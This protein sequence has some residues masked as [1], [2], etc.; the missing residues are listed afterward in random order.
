MRWNDKR[1][2]AHRDGITMLSE[3]GQLSLAIPSWLG[4]VSTN[5]SWGI[6]LPIRG[7]AV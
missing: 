2:N 4:V 5:E 3:A 7:L 6:G 1:F